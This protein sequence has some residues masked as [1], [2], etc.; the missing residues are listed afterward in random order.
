MIAVEA[1][2]VLE[3]KLKQKIYT[4]I[5]P[6]STFYPAEDYHQKYY[7]R[8]SKE[9]VRLFK[10][11]YPAGMDFTTSIAAARINGYLGGYGKKS[12]I[13]KD[14]TGTGLPPEVLKKLITVLYEGE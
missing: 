1:K 10:N 7:L 3:E 5:V 13:E 11:I 14:L 4:E 2:A 9:L 8:K 6:E 12:E